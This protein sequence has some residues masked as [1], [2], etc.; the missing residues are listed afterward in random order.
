MKNV[1]ILTID[2]FTAEALHD[3][4]YSKTTMPF[5]RKL[6]ENSIYAENYYSEG[7]HTEMGLQAMLT[8]MDTLDNSASLRRLIYADKTIFDYFYEAG[9]KLAN[10][11]WPANYYPKRLY[12][13]IEDYY[14][15]GDS[16]IE[17]IY[18]RLLYYVELYHKGEIKEQDYVDIIGCFTDSFNSYLKFLNTSIH[19]EKAYDLA[20]DR[21]KDIDFAKRYKDV[22]REQECF[23]KNKRRYVENILKN[24]GMLPE[25]LLHDDNDPRSEEELIRRKV[26][27]IYRENQVFFNKLKIR[28]VIDSLID[29]RTSFLKL[30]DSFLRYVKHEP[31][32]YIGQLSARVKQYQAFNIFEQ[33]RKNMDNCSLKTQLHFLIKLLSENKNSQKPYFVY[34]HAL[35]QHGPTQWL[36]YDMEVDE[37]EKELN[38]AKE[39]MKSNKRYKGYYAYKLGLKY[40]DNCLK[41]FFLNIKNNGLLNNT[42]VVITADH[43]SSV[44]MNPLR[45]EPAFNNCHTELFHIP[46]LI[47]DSDYKSRRLSGYFTHRDLIPTLLDICKIDLCNIGRGKSM[48][49]S[50]YCPEIALSERT[51]SGAPALLHKNAIYTVRNKKYLIEYECSVFKDFSEG[52]LEYVY[53][54][55]NDPDELKNI[56]D[57]IELKEINDL[58]DYASKRHLQLRQNYANW[59][60]QDVSKL[61]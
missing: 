40:M 21:V 43:G 1:V 39:L 9:Y 50:S 16:F 23:L 47:F 59:L 11:S 57:I 58:L 55:E 44:C 20:K 5:F 35:S 7:P 56:A 52:T 51:S 49:D 42:I 25:V 54:L 8:G 24:S 26:S 32:E 29:K 31:H 19:S 14:T 61:E 3:K 28:Q 10:I 33:N 30:A 36:S 15:Q 34:L 60:K 48:L 18:W 4:N 37:I 41:Q 45:E 46:M 12:G 6:M 53:D 22:K 17:V 38:T 13:I 27:K 2:S